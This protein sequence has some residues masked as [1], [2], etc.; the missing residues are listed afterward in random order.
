MAESR[1]VV[2]L[3]RDYLRHEKGMRQAFSMRNSP[4]KLRPTSSSAPT[5]PTKG[6]PGYMRGTAS[7]TQ[8]YSM[9]G[10]TEHQVIRNITRAASPKE[11]T[12]K[13]K[14]IAEAHR[15]LDGT[16]SLFYHEEATTPRRGGVVNGKAAM[17]SNSTQHP[18]R[19]R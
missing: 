13:P 12:P 19:V 4:E 6:L 17:E 9:S 15:Q 8:K 18:Q 10:V 11:A 2:S 7:V 5:S 1:M 14:R 3:R 16:G